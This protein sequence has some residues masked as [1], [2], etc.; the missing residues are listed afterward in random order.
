[1]QVA[2][3]LRRKLNVIK[4]FTQPRT[5]W[6]KRKQQLQERSGWGQILNLASIVSYDQVHCSAAVTRGERTEKEE[7]EE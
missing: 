2:L 1:M 4:D 3:R 6:A 7:E 5:N